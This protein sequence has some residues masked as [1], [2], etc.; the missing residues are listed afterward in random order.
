[1]KDVQGFKYIM[2]R[3]R[4]RQ[5]AL[6]ECAR[7][8]AQQQPDCEI[9]INH[10]KPSVVSS[11]L[12]P[13]TA[14]LRILKPRP[15]SS[16]SVPSWA[17]VIAGLILI[18]NCQAL[19][20]LTPP[21]PDIVIEN[22]DGTNFD[23]W[24]ETG[25]AFG[26]GPAHG[27][28]PNQM[29]VDGF[30]GAGFASSFHNGDG[31][32]GTLTSPS[33]TI[34]R[35]YIQFLIGGGG[36]AGKTCINLLSD[37]KVVRTATGPN[38]RP[39]GSEHLDW[40]AWDV[41]ELE[42]QTVILQIVDQAAGGWGHIS[43]DQIV[44]TDQ[45]NAGSIL[46][47]VSRSID[48]TQ[49]Y[50]NLPVK[51]GA[52]KRTIKIIV[53]GKTEREFDIEL[54]NDRPD[55]WAFMDT[56][57]FKDQTIVVQVDKLPDDSQGLKLI[58]QSDE[59]KDAKAIYQE[60]LRPQ[61]HFSPRRGWNN[62][63][64]GLVF[65]QGEYHLFFQHNPYGWNWGNMH[66]GHATSRDLVHWQELPEAL[67]PDAM[68][69]IYSGSAVVDWQNT[70]GF[71][72][73]DQPPLVLFYTQAGDQ[74]A[75]CLAYSTDGGHSFTKYAGNPVVP[76]I[77]A[78]NRDPK[79]FWYEPAKEWVMVLWVE[80]QG[81]N[82]IRFLTS[83]NL[84]EWTT[85]SQ[86]NDFFECPDFFELPVDGDPANKKWVLT[87]ANSEYEVGSFDGH[88]FTA[89]TAK[90]P[91]QRG[92]GYYATQTYSDLPAN[93]GRRIQIGWLQAPSPGM[94]FNQCLS[95]PHELRLTQTPKG[96]RLTYTPVRELQT[97]RLPSHDLG[98]LTL[99][100][101]TSNP[102]ADVKAELMELHAAFEPGAASGVIFNV[103]GAAI[104]F[105][106]KKQELEVNDIHVAA[107]WHDGRQDITV[108]CDRTSLE[109]FASDGLVYIP[110]PFQPKTDDLDVGVQV[111]G[112]STKFDSLQ[113][114]QLKSAWEPIDN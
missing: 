32:L 18:T 61:I 66:W 74:F 37:G 97:L 54:A 29:P 27:A 8:R 102:L 49:R 95:L 92:R 104:R 65:Y 24:K 87:A 71:G 17:R 7:P 14:T 43:I 78:G 39:G 1:M 11:L 63:P 82:T 89:E 68:G 70:G 85:V 26:P 13:W 84:K 106:T 23:D 44:Q 60:E 64:N 58:N 33:F 46:S 67:Y 69:T 99:Q 3:F 76:E 15:G 108:Y 53:N 83:P 31:S 109:I 98:P 107:P 59:I 100:P 101:D 73:N 21:R 41:S 42:G 93:D 81:H 91:G 77:T 45:K 57:A 20:A 38:T 62:D 51:N 72:K 114:Y 80:W 6:P 30:L 79:V 94:P 103:R 28:L 35:K 10:R 111:E 88:S 40:Q 22:F 86:A 110:L 5:T 4:N 105:D 96:P 90:L 113:L 9:N 55:W 48:M 34:Q 16:P 56:S 12:W 19:P 47:D 112:G 50:L 52:P 2:S 36:F 25:D 75:Q